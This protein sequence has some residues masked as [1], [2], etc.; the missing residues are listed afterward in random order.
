[1]VLAWALP[2]FTRLRSPLHEQA[3]ELD[4]ASVD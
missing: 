1:V 3:D 4:E 2:G